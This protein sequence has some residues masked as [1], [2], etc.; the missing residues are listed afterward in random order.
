MAGTVMHDLDSR[1]AAA[2]PLTPTNFYILLSLAA[3]ERHGYS[4]MQEVAS[5]TEGAIR[6]W[7]GTLY[8]TIRSLLGDGLI[9][10]LPERPESAAEDER[11][12]YY[13]LTEQG[14]RA[15]EGEAQRLASL[16]G[17][18]SRRQLPPPQ[19]GAEGGK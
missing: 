5:L 4:I 1:R 8:R 11:R 13:R 18:V 2:A 14:R 19:G 15:A 17:L 9:A 10:E 6:L 12:R 3:G 16:A 7:P